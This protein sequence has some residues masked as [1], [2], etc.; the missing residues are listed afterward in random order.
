MRVLETE[1]AAADIARKRAMNVTVSRNAVKARN[2]RA[3]PGNLR[4]QM[5]RAGCKF[6]RREIARL[7]RR[8]LRKIGEADAVR[9]QRSVMF[10]PEH[11][12]R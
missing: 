8:A 11:L 7:R 3:V 9:E 12:D 4:E 2:S 1:F 10:R 6:R 5:L